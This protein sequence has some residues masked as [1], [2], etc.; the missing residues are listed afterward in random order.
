MIKGLPVSISFNLQSMRTGGPVATLNEL[1]LI[2][3][4]R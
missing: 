4:S 2:S 3:S 1:P